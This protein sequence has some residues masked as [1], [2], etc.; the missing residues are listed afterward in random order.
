[1]KRPTLPERFR[2]PREADPKAPRGSSRRGATRTTMVWLGL[3]AAALCLYATA[4]TVPTNEVAIVARFGDMRRV[5][6]EPGLHFRWP[7]P[8]DS[9]YRVDMRRHLLDPEPGELLTKDADN[10]EI[11]SFV[12]WRVADPRL[13]Y[14]SLRSREGAEARLAPVLRNAMTKVIN[15]TA[16]EDMISTQEVRDRDLVA[17]TRDVKELVAAECAENGYG[18]QI[19]LVGIERVT[20]SAANMPAIER[21]MESERE[22]VAKGISIEANEWANKIRLEAATEVADITS[23]AAAEA[24]GILAKGKAEAVRIEA[25]AI[26]LNEDLYL[27]MKELEVAERAFEGG[28]II[29]SASDPL[30]ETL[31]RPLGAR[32]GPR[33][34]EGK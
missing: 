11:D 10:L 17:V 34:G 25:E 12:A 2:H 22:G 9:V 30:L 33:T 20:F 32:R 19:E 14:A 21:A 18:I 28:L 26:A 29:L 5:I 4:F 7:A 16:L 27:F 31:L 15:G 1:M 24:Q 13:F 3:A 6:D 8:V 23:K